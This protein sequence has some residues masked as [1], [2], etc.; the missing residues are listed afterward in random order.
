[1]N[2]PN[3][4]KTA[5]FV[6]SRF[7]D[8]LL[9]DDFAMSRLGFN[10]D[11]LKQSSTRSL[12][13][14]EEKAREK[15][16]KQQATKQEF[17]VYVSEYFHENL[18]TYLEQRVADP[19][20]IFTELLQFE[21]EIPKLFDACAAKA[22]GAS[23]F[24]Q[25]IARIPWLNTSFIE[26]INNPPFREAKSIKP[27]VENLG[28]AIRYVGLDNTKLV[29][30]SQVAQHFLPHSTEPYNTFKGRYWQYVVATA[31]CSRQLA[32]YYQL[33]EVVAFF[34]G[35]FHAIGTSLAL[36]LYLRAFDTVRVAQMKDALKNGRRD[37][38]TVLNGLE[39]DPNFISDALTKFSN[40]ISYRVFEK[41][42]LKYAVV[43][44]FVE[45]IKDKLAF[46]QASPMT[47]V[48]MQARTF[49]QYKILQKARL[50]E[51]DE[52]KIFL[53]NYKIG[54]AVIG[55]LNKVNLTNIKYSK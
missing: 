3:Y 18:F 42:G 46:D 38:E 29:V 47:Q 40:Q 23:H 36:R 52:A 22:A 4:Q 9:S 28:L 11:E 53:T 33:N 14:I 45:E 26:T 30:L 48:L 34:L 43:A 16:L 24:E 1:M 12:L 39:I 6:E 44:P 27:K 19:D 54:N 7:M 8:L 2:N 51:L 25:I 31:N 55:E 50:I 37:I 5:S 35:L 17:K 21:P 41:L 13:D 10:R 20:Y 15:K 32:R 49:S